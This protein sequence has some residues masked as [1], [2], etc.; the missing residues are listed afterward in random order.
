MGMATLLVH[1]WLDGGSS[2]DVGVTT[3]AQRWRWR[4][5]GTGKVGATTVL[6]RR[7]GAA[8]LL[9]RCFINDGSSDNIGITTLAQQQ[10]TVMAGQWQAQLRSGDGGLGATIGV[11]TLLAHCW[12]DDG[13]S[14]DVGVTTQVQQWQWHNDGRHNTGAMMV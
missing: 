5:D 11:A 14:N 1:C 4:D 6:A 13:S 12:L 9:G 7:L 10:T 2:D 8:A 3:S